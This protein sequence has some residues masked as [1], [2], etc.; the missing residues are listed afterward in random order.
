VLI[1]PDRSHANNS[2]DTVA[3]DT[4]ALILGAVGCMLFRTDWGSLSIFDYQEVV[5]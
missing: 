2:S 4:V 5:I 1:G 3:C